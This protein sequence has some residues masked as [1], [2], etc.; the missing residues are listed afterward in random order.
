MLDNVIVPTIFAKDK[1]TFSKKIEMLEFSPIIH[2]DFMDGKFTKSGK[3]ISIDDMRE[4]I[5]KDDPREF[6]IHL[7][8]NNPE[9][10]IKNLLKISQINRVYLQHGAF[11]DKVHL[12][13]S[14]NEFKS[15][16]YEIFLVLNPNED[17]SIIEQYSEIISGVMLMSVEPG[18]EGQEFIEST[19]E[20]LST[21]RKIHPEI[22]IV[23]D[24]GLN[25]KTIAKLVLAG[26]NSLCVGSYIS[27]SETPKE[28]YEKLKVLVNS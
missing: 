9:K 11:D 24:G 16:N 1:G 26:V 14:V 27:S 18:K 19:N 17:V 15:R 6:R 21:L 5:P 25:P 22:E 7:M 13:M 12:E 3:T 28:N 23:I 4:L 2:L 8:A 20:K 10:F